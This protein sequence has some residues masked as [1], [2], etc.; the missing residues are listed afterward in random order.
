MKII[1]LKDHTGQD[2]ILR[3][4]D[5][6]RLIDSEVPH[7][8][9]NENIASQCYGY[10][11]FVTSVSQRYGE[12]SDAPG[13][14]GFFTVAFPFEDGWLE[15][16]DVPIHSVYRILGNDDLQIDQEETLGHEQ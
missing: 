1:N 12:D 3:K 5:L 15:L 14:A 2:P 8:D 13:Q 7:E 4:G 6:V 9:W 10:S 11:G 16:E